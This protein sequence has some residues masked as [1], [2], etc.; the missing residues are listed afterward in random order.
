[1]ED[2]LTRRL[3]ELGTRPVPPGTSARHLAAMA[4][5]GIRRE[6]RRFGRV[7][8]GLA[9][10]TGFLL[11]GSGLAMAGALPTAAQDFAA[12]ALAQVGVDAPRSPSSA[13]GQCVSAAARSFNGGGD[14]GEGSEI[15]TEAG[16]TESGAPE[17]D[18]T[19]SGDDDGAERSNAAFKAA[20]AEC[21][22]LKADRG[23]AKADRGPAA[24][25]PAA[26]GDP[27]TGPPPWS[28]GPG[29]GDGSRSWTSEEKRTFCDTCPQELEADEEGEDVT[30]DELGE[31]TSEGDGEDGD[32]KAVE[33]DDG[34]PCTGK[35]PW[36][37]PMTKAERAAAKAAGRGAGC[38]PESEAP[39]TEVPETEV[40][41][42]E[43]PAT[44]SPADAP[45]GVG[46]P[47]V[48][49]GAA[50]ST[51]APAPTPAQAE[52]KKPERPAPPAQASTKSNGGAV[53]PSDQVSGPAAGGA[54]N[55]KGNGAQ[56]A[57]GGGN[58]SAG[59]KDR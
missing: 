21:E 32:G 59:K 30:D 25:T 51:P 2:E 29:G 13:Y 8:V 24:G 12:E 19:E 7:A 37:G 53:D 40:P 14:R 5:I 27:C 50:V 34:D 49:E 57:S 42:T 55:G 36:A 10:A 17:S 46:E 44:D 48:V 6:P 1:M 4:G 28:R 16:G 3:S 39:E 11:G 43:A 20:K 41:E 23:S 35:P 33:A 31:G 47:G 38:G 15:E 56:S 26:D 54:G 22:A 52:A 9:A 58:S 18:G 45:G